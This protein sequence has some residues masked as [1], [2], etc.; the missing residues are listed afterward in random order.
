M[1]KTYILRRIASSSLFWRIR[2]LL[3][4]RWMV[5]YSRKDSKFIEKLVAEYNIKSVLDFGCASGAT[6]FNIKSR[7]ESSLVYGIDINPRAISYC[8]SR[9]SQQFESGYHFSQKISQKELRMFLDQNEIEAFDLVIFDRV[10]YCL[11]QEKIQDILR[12][13]RPKANLILIDDFVRDIEFKF[14]GYVHRNWDEILKKYGFSPVLNQATVYS[15]VR[16]AN[17]RTML[18]TN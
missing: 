2:H 18:Y 13:I 14:T 5:S 10:L 4:P 15:P 6:L 9:F 7:N 16:N 3:Q 11:D 1:L 12:I 17:A 8:Q